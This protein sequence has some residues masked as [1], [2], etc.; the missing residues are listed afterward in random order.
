MRC[1]KMICVALAL[2]VMLLT[3]AQ[4]APEDRDFIRQEGAFA[5]TGDTPRG[6]CVAGD[7]LYLYGYSYIYTYRMGD[8][9]LAAA[10]FAL[11]EAGE[12]ASRELVRLF[13]DGDALR[14]LL[15]VFRN[16][17]NGYAPVRLEIADVEIDGGEARFGGLAEAEV[18][19][20]TAS[21]GDGSS[22]ELVQIN[23][24]VCAGGYLALHVVTD[25]GASKAY[26][27][28]ADGGAGEFLELEYVRAIAAWEDGQLL[29]ETFDYDE[30]RCEF[31]LCDPADGGLTP[32]CDP[33][34]TEKPLYGVAY[35]AES[36]RL[37]YMADGYVMAA[38]GFDF[39]GAEPAAELFVRYAEEAACM[40][41]PGDYYVCCT[42]FDGTAIRATAPGALP[43]TRITVQSAGVDDT[44]LGAYRKFG[45]AHGDVGV[46]LRENYAE[47]GAIARDM[48]NRDS[49]V[50]VYMLSVNTE[51][52][53]ALYSR[54]YLAALDDPAIVEAVEEMYPAVRDAITREG[55]IVAVP[56][57]AYGW[58]LCLDYEGFERIG[59]PRAEM[60]DNWSD[61]LD[62]LPELPEMLPEDGSVRIFE[63]YYTR[64]QARRE[65]VGAILNSWH[66]YL[67]AR[68]EEVY[69]DSP[70]LRA[71][72]EKAMA[73]DLAAMGLPE[74]GEDASYEMI[75]VSGGGGTADRDYTLVMPSGGCSIG[76]FYYAVEPALLSVIPGEEQPVPL[77]LAVAFV[78]PYS[79]NPDLAQ[80]FLAT[81]LD[82][83]NTSTAYNLSDK[84]NDPVRSSYYERAMGYI[85]E[86]MERA[87]EG[88]ES[89]DPLDVPSWEERIASIE[90]QK[91]MID[92]TG[93]E[94]SEK[95]LAWYR[96]HDDRLQVERYHGVSVEYGTGEYAELAQQLLDGRMDA[97]A[98]LRE[99][100]H[101]A[102]MKAREGN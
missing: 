92:E 42:N 45:A 25:E 29:I 26:V 90:A 100:D 7:V 30:Q 22:L 3:A 68:G 35:G 60:P 11:P 71:V 40:V 94:V 38:E 21:Y 9:D 96:G 70:E 37:F 20:L 53:D 64:Q 28:P 81:I 48:M 77:G 54:G 14:A 67:D 16:D 99:L 83:L 43:Q 101:R 27:L 50:D 57:M 10:E 36:G 12:N 61:F 65:L 5:D 6:G 13:A 78:N 80:E 41:L 18:G 63:D 76:S 89:A 8:S 75:V 46:V 33:L 84:L 73:L 55:E 47:D 74:G 31:W 17:E 97:G 93:W 19:D 85:Q 32:A 44:L 98:F 91:Q 49:S 82:G 66:L 79:P 4:A 59:I 58:T 69:Y 87:R 88:L 15:A 56:V 39:E 23:N 34:R 72:L 24:A 86:E 62:L 1:R 95:D 2:A 51:A 102:Q 52:Y